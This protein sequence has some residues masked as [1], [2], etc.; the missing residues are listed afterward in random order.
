VLS[1]GDAC[2]SDAE[3][4]RQGLVLGVAVDR[5]MIA[6]LDPTVLSFFPDYADL[7]MPEKDHNT[8]RHCSRCRWASP[9]T[10]MRLTPTRI[11]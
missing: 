9:G 3:E 5:A 8:I 6:D 10:T 2:G 7:R 11:R 1:A 4:P